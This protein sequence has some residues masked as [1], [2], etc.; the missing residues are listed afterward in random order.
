MKNKNIEKGKM[1]ITTNAT[2]MYLR[3]SRESVENFLEK[4]NCTKVEYVG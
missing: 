1:F 4:K 2:D 3:N